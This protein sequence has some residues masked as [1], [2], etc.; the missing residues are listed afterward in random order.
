M[1]SAA[2]HDDPVAADRRRDMVDA[3]VDAADVAVP[4]HQFDDDP[5]ERNV[6]ELVALADVDMQHP[7]ASRL[8]NGFNDAAFA[9]FA[10]QHAEHGRFKRVR[11]RPRDPVD[12]G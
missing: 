11:L 5:F 6:T 4:A 3:V 2:G 7:F 12:R 1:V 9:V 8:R 10:H